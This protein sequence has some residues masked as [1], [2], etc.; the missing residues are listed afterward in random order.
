MAAV[1]QALRAAAVLALG[2]GRTLVGLVG[3]A[4]GARPARYDLPIP[5]FPIDVVLVSKPEHIQARPRPC[6]CR[7]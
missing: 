1:L 2:A 6:A 5:G 3:A 4:I 7:A